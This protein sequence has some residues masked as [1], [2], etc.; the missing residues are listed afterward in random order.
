[1]IVEPTTELFEE[2]YYITV[3]ELI[4][5]VR[6]SLINLQKWLIYKEINL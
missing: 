5:F 1:M 4:K 3:T 2:K 6:Q